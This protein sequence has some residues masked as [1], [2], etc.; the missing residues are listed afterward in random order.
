MLQPE[1]LTVAIIENEYVWVENISNRKCAIQSKFLVFGKKKNK[2]KK[3]DHV[4]Q[5]VIFPGSMN[6]AIIN[7]KYLSSASSSV[8]LDF[9]SPL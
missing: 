2:K 7:A 4:L 1:L 8:K 6:I 9:V 5:K 3:M